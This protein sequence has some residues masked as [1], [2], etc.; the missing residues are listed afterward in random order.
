MTAK[1]NLDRDRTNNYTQITI[2]FVLPFSLIY[3]TYWLINKKKLNNLWN[4]YVNGELKLTTKDK[5]QSRIF[6]FGVVFIALLGIAILLF[7]PPETN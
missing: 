2:Y 7:Y 5:I 1:M 3:F 6:Y 4:Q